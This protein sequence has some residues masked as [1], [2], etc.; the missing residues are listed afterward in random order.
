M[1]TGSTPGSPTASTKPSARRATWHSMACTTPTP[2]ASRSLGSSTMWRKRGA[3]LG[4]T[5]GP[6]ASSRTDRPSKPSASTCSSRAWPLDSSAPTSC[7]LRTWVEADP[8][9]QVHRAFPPSGPRA[10]GRQRG[11]ARI[12]DRT[13]DGEVIQRLEGEVPE[14]EDVVHRIVEEAADAGR[15][16]AGRLRLEV[17]HLPD[18][19][20]LPEQAPVERRPVLDQLCLVLGE[21]AERE[22]AL[23]G[24][25]LAAA[26]L[27]RELPR[28]A[29]LE[30]VERQARGAARRRLPGEVRVH[31]CLELLHLRRIARER[32]QARV[33]ALHAV[34]EQA[35]VDRRL[36]G[37]RVPGHRHHAL[38][39]QVEAP[40]RDRSLSVTREKTAPLVNDLSCRAHGFRDAPETASMISQGTG[41]SGLSRFAFPY[42]RCLASSRT[43]S[44][45]RFKLFCATFP[46]HSAITSSALSRSA[47][48][49]SASRSRP[50]SA[51]MVASAASSS[52]RA[53]QP[54]V[55]AAMRS[56]PIA[57]P[58]SCWQ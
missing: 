14:A 51:S 58:A 31:A 46:G 7:S 40:G 42:Q 33:D 52:T 27:R 49:K 12:V 18:R 6:T 47:P 34:H 15:A 10:V 37:N 26:H 39:H 20:R 2:Y 8:L 57:W 24:D 1:S 44:S 16:H 41:S 50:S 35:E 28:V 53:D 13:A 19:A 32:V 54:S 38:E 30:Q 23:A 36:P 4:R 45:S 11:E 43:A 9:R 55:A 3:W 48:S 25:V 21:H 17:Q 5:S 56:V 29:A 22:R